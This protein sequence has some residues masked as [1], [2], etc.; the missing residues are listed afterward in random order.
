MVSRKPAFLAVCL[1]VLFLP[2]TY[3]Q[4]AQNGITTPE[5]SSRPPGGG[6]SGVIPVG[7]PWIEFGFGVTGSFAVGCQPA[8]PAGLGCGPSSS[9][10]SI[11][12]EAPPWTF[13]APDGGATLIVTDAYL[14]GDVFE[15]FD[16]GVSIGAIARPTGNDSCNDDPDPCVAN[17]LVGHGFFLLDPGPHQITIQLLDSPFGGGAAY[18]RVEPS[19]MDFYAVVPCRVVDTRLPD[20]P[21]GGPILTSGQL[22]SF[23]ISGVCGIPDG[24]QAVSLNVTAVGSTGLGVLEVFRAGLF[25]TG[26]SS[27]TFGAG[28]TRTNNGFVGLAAGRLTVRPLI[29][30]SPGNVHVVID[31]NGYFR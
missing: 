3:A 21:Y 30:V 7:G 6:L 1:A 12:G 5:E 24:A 2:A 18:F 16:F 13:T 9:G 10:N 4:E 17:P 29:E 11:F 28:Q 26:T 22:R 19:A 25:G 14:L 20:G 15:I 27:L 23:R 8:D 31:V